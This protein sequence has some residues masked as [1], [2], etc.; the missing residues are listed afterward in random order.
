MGPRDT[1]GCFPVNLLGFLPNPKALG[2]HFWDLHPP[3]QKGVVAPAPL[4]SILDCIHAVYQVHCC[5]VAEPPGP[6]GILTRKMT[7]ICQQVVQEAA[8]SES[9]RKSSVPSHP[10]LSWTFTGNMW[11]TLGRYRKKKKNRYGSQLGKKA[12]CDGTSLS[13]CL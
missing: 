7:A 8:S 13:L 10:R 3:L 2:K 6:C 9:M 5:S 1:V 4:V 11:W 12:T